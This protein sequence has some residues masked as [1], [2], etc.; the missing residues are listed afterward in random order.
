MKIFY[1]NQYLTLIPATK[2]DFCTGCCFS[3]RGK[4]CQAPALLTVVC[5]TMNKIYKQETKKDI[6]YESQI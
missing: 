2:P 4:Y 1:K 6:F 3:I 5:A